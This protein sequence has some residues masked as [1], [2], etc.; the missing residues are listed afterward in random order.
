MIDDDEDYVGRVSNSTN[1]STSIDV[2]HPRIVRYYQIV[3]LSE[4]AMHVARV[5]QSLYWFGEFGC[6]R[7]WNLAHQILARLSFDGNREERG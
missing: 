4:T 2:Y 3:C 6:I 1:L 5:V 7:R